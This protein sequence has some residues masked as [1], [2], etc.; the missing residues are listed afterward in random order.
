MNNTNEPGRAPQDSTSKKTEESVDEIMASIMANISKEEPSPVD[1]VREAVVQQ[2]APLDYDVY[3]YDDKPAVILGAGMAA[4]SGM[5]DRM[6]PFE[7]EVPTTEEVEQAAQAAQ[8]YQ[9]AQAEA[10]A[11]PAQQAHPTQPAPQQNP[12]TT[13]VYEP[14]PDYPL[15]APAPAPLPEEN[16]YYENLQQSKP[17][18]PQVIPNS[19]EDMHKVE[20]DF[21][22]NTPSKWLT[23]F[24]FVIHVLLSAGVAFYIFHF[25][26]SASTP[27]SPVASNEFMMTLIALG[28]IILVGVILALIVG[29]TSKAKSKQ[30]GWIASG[31]GRAGISTLIGI[32]LWVVAMV[33]ADAIA[34]GKISL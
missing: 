5:G 29:I 1:G 14:V 21:G 34:T 24:P 26:T 10:Q 20:F 31:F 7:G 11:H 22:E 30:P 9:Q 2:P 4:T 32:I 6:P 18:I 16:P 19:P 25:F 12:E 27:V 33:L 17:F 15:V 13:A 23:V 28:A 8:Q 3:Q